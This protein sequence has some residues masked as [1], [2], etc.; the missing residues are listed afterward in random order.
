VYPAE[1]KDAGIH[2]YDHYKSVIV[3]TPTVIASSAYL[4]KQAVITYRDNSAGIN[5]FGVDPPDENKVMHLKPDIVEGNY[6]DLSGSGKGILIGDDPMSG[7][8][9]LPL[10][11]A[12]FP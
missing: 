3:S 9:S 8:R 5:I 1:D 4:E 7:Y 2:L 11:Q 10:N 12:S 6:E